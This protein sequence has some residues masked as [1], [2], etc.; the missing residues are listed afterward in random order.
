MVATKR[1]LIREIKRLQRA[2]EPLNY[3]AANK[4]HNTLLVHATRQ[5]GSWRAAIEA[6]GFDY[7]Q[8]SK[9]LR[10][11]KDEV[12]QQLRELHAQGKI[13]AV[14]TLAAEYPKLFSACRRHFGT[15]RLALAAA[16]FDYQQLLDSH[17]WRWT[18]AKCIA[19]LQTRDAAG[20]SVSRAVIMRDE[21]NER[22]FCYAVL[23]Q[24]GTWG[25]A[26]QAAKINRRAARDR[27]RIW[28]Q[29]RV[30]REILARHE[31]GQLLHTEVMLRDALPL[32]AAGRRHF[33]TWEKAVERAGINYRQVRGGLRGFSRERTKQSLRRR[34]K[35]NQC[36]AACVRRETP[37]LYRA[38]IHHFGDWD[39]ALRAAMVRS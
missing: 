19:H 20:K 28:P 8:I 34:L 18:K 31:S 16:G 22:N 2:G 13:F 35:K 7:Q 12:L 27:D 1:A 32:H 25:A 9:T 3:A 24:F 6:A 30:L 39:A 36:S 38:A 15:G 17:P 23:H 4:S 26:L 5:F 29:E 21:A 14:A 11:S 33:G 10:W 37:L